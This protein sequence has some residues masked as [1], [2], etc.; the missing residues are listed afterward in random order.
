MVNTQKIK[1]AWVLAHELD[2]S[3]YRR[4]IKLNLGNAGMVKSYLWAAYHNDTSRLNQ[5]RNEIAVVMYDKKN[6]V[7]CWALVFDSRWGFFGRWKKEVHIYTRA[8]K[9][10]KGYAGHL[11]QEIISAYSPKK[12]YCLGNSKFFKKYKIRHRSYG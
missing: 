3:L 10:G 11:L 12:L 1:V 9:R 6:V 8:S 2:P 7:V 4:L 5:R